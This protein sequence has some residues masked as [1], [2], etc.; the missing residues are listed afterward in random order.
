MQIGGIKWGNKK[1]QGGIKMALTDAAIR[2][3]KPAE[4]PK[5]LFDGGGLFLLVAPTGTKSWR[6]KYRFLG[7][8]KLMTLGLYPLVSLKEAREHSLEAKKLLASGKDP[9]V[10]KRLNRLQLQCTFEIV[11]REWHEKQG[12]NWS[13]HYRIRT[14]ASL[15]KNAFPY[16][17]DRPIA[18]V[19]AQ[20]LLM[21]LR[22][23]EDRG[24]LATAH[25]VR[26]LCSSIFRYAIATGRAERNPVP[27]I[28]GA[29]PAHLRK[30]HPAITDPDKVGELM[31]KIDDYRGITVRCA[32]L[33]LALTFCRPGEIR[34]AEW[35]EFDFE[36]RLWRIPAAKMKMSRD[37]L[38]PLSN[39]ALAILEYMRM[40]SDHARY[41]FLNQ[42][43]HSRPLGPST[44]SSALRIMGYS[45]DEMTPHGFRAM[46]STLLNEQGYP[47]DAIERQLAHV[48]HERI[49]GIYNRAEYLP[50]RRHMMDD[51]AAYLD[52]LRERARQKA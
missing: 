23:L 15:V 19:S 30:S 3:A 40:F 42:R 10:E 26:G 51:W 9:S 43:S 13:D 16:I 24:T 50:E 31:L 49:R 22:R 17:G 18:E 33:F 11:A 48:P 41:V 8:E 14:L 7:K 45:K 35:S 1:R 29:L 5:K 6:L 21:M 37:H 27:D 2:A 36:D 44:F 32:L 20:E 25:A 4:K 38:V 28:H 46:A 39:Q 12:P 52:T 34:H 47:P